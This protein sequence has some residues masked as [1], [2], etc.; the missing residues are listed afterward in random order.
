MPPADHDPIAFIDLR[1]QYRRLKADIDAALS[2]AL[3]DGRF[4]LGPPVEELESALTAR[5]GVP[6]A[7]SCASGTDALQIALMAE[8]I[9]PGDAVF[10]PGFTFPATAGVVALVGATPVFV[11][12]AEESCMMDPAD[13]AARI[14][15]VAAGG[16]LTPRAVIAADLF[17]QAADYDALAPLAAER[18]LLLI[19]DAAQSFGGASGGRPVGSLAPV[20]TTSF[21]PAKPLGGY[22]DGGSLFTDDAER[23]ARWR[24]IRQHG[25]GDGKYDIVRVGLNSRLDTLQAAILLVKLAAF[26][27]EID[28]RERVATTYDSVLAG[29]VGLPGRLPLRRSTWAQYTIRLE[30][31]DAVQAALAAQGI[32]TAIHYP[33]PMHLQPAYREYGEGPARYP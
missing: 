4:V 6:H 29:A 5:A 23:A 19:D 21:Y 3:A 24:S 28:A 10:V 15:R 33:V 25:Q 26:D 9:G 18:G 11:D 16:S 17:G 31:R 30:R 13:L 22:G 12:V 14:D 2:H 20:T 27:A 8:G 1:A 32:P 7:V